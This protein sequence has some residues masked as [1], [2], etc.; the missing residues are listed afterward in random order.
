MKPN[1]VQRFATAVER[2]SVAMRVYHQAYGPIMQQRLIQAQRDMV[3]VG[4]KAEL[5]RMNKLGKVEFPLSPDTR[6]AI[7]S[8]C[9]GVP[10][11]LIVEQARGTPKGRGRSKVKK[12][13]G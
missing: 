10:R 13:K 8:L 7:Q 9:F 2:L 11:R 4:R 5:Q 12:G 1:D 3:A 6:R